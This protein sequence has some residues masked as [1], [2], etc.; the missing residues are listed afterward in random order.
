ML[1]TYLPAWQSGSGLSDVLGT[2]AKWRILGCRKL[3]NGLGALLVIPEIS[4]DGNLES[5]TFLST[6]PS[7]IRTGTFASL[8]SGG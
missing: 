1:I 5:L 3:T 8:L 4:G 7:G 2:E 6:S